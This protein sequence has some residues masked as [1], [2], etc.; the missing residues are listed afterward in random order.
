[1]PDKITSYDMKR[2]ALDERANK[3]V[4]TRVDLSKELELLDEHL[5]DALLWA[6]AHKDLSLDAAAK[7]LAVIRLARIYVDAGI[8]GA[9]D[10]C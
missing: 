5:A 1:M 7:A 8:G 9:A 3:V 4:L 10:V 2:A 6:C